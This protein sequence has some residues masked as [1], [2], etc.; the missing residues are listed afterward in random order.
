[1]EQGRLVVDEAAV[2]VWDEVRD[3]VEA[4]WADH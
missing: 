3:K 2:E 4:E 1:M